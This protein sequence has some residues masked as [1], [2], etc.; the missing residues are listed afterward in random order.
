MFCFFRD[1]VPFVAS[2]SRATRH[3]SLPRPLI[4]VV[5][6]SARFASGQR[7]P[8]DAHGTPLTARSS[9]FR[10]SPASVA[11]SALPVVGGVPSA[12][13]A[14]RASARTAR[15]DFRVSVGLSS[16][17]APTE[18][19][20]AVT[21]TP[22]TAL[23]RRV[24]PYTGG[25]RVA[26]VAH[27]PKALRASGRACSLNDNRRV[28]HVRLAAHDTLGDARPFRSQ[29]RAGVSPRT[30]ARDVRRRVGGLLGGRGDDGDSESSSGS[31]GSDGGDGSGE[32]D[33]DGKKTFTARE[34][35]RFALRRIDSDGYW[36]VISSG[37]VFGTFL[38]ESY[39][40][41]SFGGWDVLY[42]DDISWYTGLI[43]MNALEDIEDAYNLLF[44]FEFC[45][46][47]WAFEFKKEFWTNPVTAVDFLATIPPVLSFFDIIYRG[48]PLFRFL[49]LLRVLRLLRLL[50]RSPNSVLF[51][52]VRSDSMSIQLVGIGAEF[53]CIF[54]IAA[55]VIYDLEYTV[56]PN[57]N[58]LNDTLYWAI[59]TL[60]GIGQPFEVVTAGGRVATVLSIAVALIVVPG[61]LAKLA[62]VAGAQDMMRGM[63]EDGEDSWDE[64]DPLQSADF[65]EVGTFS[66]SAAYAA[67][68][69]IPI[70]GPNPGIGTPF[71]AFAPPAV[72]PQPP[73]KS[74]GRGNGNGKNADRR[75]GNGV[76]EDAAPVT[77]SDFGA[78]GLDT[79]PSS[80]VAMRGKVWDGR[81][82]DQC[83]LQIHETDAR[84]C[85]RCGD[86]LGQT[87]GPLYVKRETAGDTV[88]GGKKKP[89]KMLPMPMKAGAPRGGTMGR[90]G[91]DITGATMSNFREKNDGGGGGSGKK[92]K[93]SRKN[94]G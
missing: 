12:G 41:S 92:S 31:D 80:T 7:D 74:N 59:L 52:L 58:N 72:V 34:R 40:M 82:C 17:A 24:S 11:P 90:I 16:G 47:A 18:A 38:L 5:D 8:R 75:N 30:P 69:P 51:G 54:I 86:K 55:G 39:N 33:G 93:R 37:I 77:V 49:R 85:R 87:L 2:E 79:A 65:E 70:G 73:R 15:A 36:A 84:F 76:Q 45:L 13:G 56:N 78:D 22:A 60:T 94:R 91:L 23:A 57:V 81:E 32:T 42:R 88:S 44:F 29:R 53:V 20:G 3:V 27:I 66:R 4:A 71:G 9:G 68:T 25:S 28:R 89:K 35:M 1:S 48:S 50:D 26:R 10:V 19:M 67:A 63:M 43:S 14:P 83:G 6:T 62:T 46:R 61:Q 21:V 64:N